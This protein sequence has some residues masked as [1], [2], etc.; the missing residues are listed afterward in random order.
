MMTNAERRFM[1][2]TTKQIETVMAALI[3]MTDSAINTFDGH[4]E[5]ALYEKLYLKIRKMKDCEEF[6]ALHEAGA[7]QETVS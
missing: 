7:Y 1:R 5:A 6:D 3:S 2:Q 4:P